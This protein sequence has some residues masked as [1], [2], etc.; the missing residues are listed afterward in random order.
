VSEHARSAKPFL[1]QI[2]SLPPDVPISVGS[3]LYPHVAHREFVYLFPTVSD[4]R[5]I[6]LDVTGP[7]SPVG[8][9]DQRQIVRELLEYGE[10]GMAESDHGFLLLERGL[11]EYRQSSKFDQVFLAGDS[12]PQVP[13]DISF[14]GVL[15]LVG[16]DRDIRPVVRP[17]LVVELSTYWRVL[18]P[19]QTE[20]RLVFFFWDEQWQLVRIQPEERA[21]HWYP[22]WLW[23]PG[24]VIEVRLPP[25]PLGDLPHVGAAVLRPG[26]DDRD[27][28]GR[29]TPITAFGRQ[30][31]SLWEHDT[32]LELTSP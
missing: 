22:T 26:A 5:F 2:N 29:V 10:F 16:Y 6:L 30:T 27:L 8:V 31:I 24:Q 11:E 12:K 15:Q 19:L 23:E 21:L 28:E 4:A 18:A 3:N 17:E 13:L 20:Y 32:I 9:G 25:L 14:G 7:S 1:E